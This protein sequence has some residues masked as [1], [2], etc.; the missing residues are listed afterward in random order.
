MGDIR[1]IAHYG[2]TRA[3]DLRVAWNTLIHQRKGEAL[4][5]QSPP[6]FD[7]LGHRDQKCALSLAVFEH[8]SAA[9]GVVPLWS[10]DATLAFQIKKLRLAELTYSCLRVL[11]ATLLVPQSPAVFE[12][13]F[14][15]LADRFSQCD[16]IEI[17]GLPTSSELWNFL[18]SR[19]QLRKRFFVYIPS[20]RRICQWTD[21]P[22]TFDLYMTRFRRKKRYNLKRQLARLDQH[23]GGSLKLQRI[24]HAADV[25]LFMDALERLTSRQR[26]EGIAQRELVDLAQRGLLLSYVLMSS[27]GPCSLAFGT[28]FGSTQL[29][30]LFAHDSSIEHL[31]PGTVLH[32]LMMRDLIDAKVV[33]RVDYGFGEPRYRLGNQLE[34]RVTVMLVRRTIA[35]WSGIMAHATFDGAIDVMKQMLRRRREKDSSAR[36][37]DEPDPV[38]LSRA[39]MFRQVYQRICT[40]TAI[41]A[42]ATAA[43][44]VQPVAFAATDKPDPV[45]ERG[46]YVVTITGCNDC[47]TPDYAMSGGNV[48]ESKWLT[49]DALGWRGSWGTTYAVN[50]R[51]Y[52]QNLSEKEWVAKAKTLE[53]RPPMPWFNL[54]RMSDN[55]LRAIHRYIHSLGPAG[56]AA[57]AFVPPNQEPRPPYVTF[58]APPK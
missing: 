10:A 50:L 18:C 24:E 15:K 47:H 6:Y 46:R 16:L 55:D 37:D 3:D 26:M 14:V 41:S 30:H 2:E 57:P 40:N 32:T 19:S 49:G 21:V 43:A 51:L 31:S 48:D 52:M 25:P 1:V 34:E 9:A 17:K 58:P 39:N 56:Q 27:T 4:F 23:A 29:V 53:T 44:L 54:R 20:G 11:G 33:R 42:L 7:H 35:N 28:R 45:R 22:D 36:G 5:Y 8:E 38:I 13:L 12:Q